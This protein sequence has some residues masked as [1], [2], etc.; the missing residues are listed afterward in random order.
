[1][2]WAVRHLPLRPIGLVGRIVFRKR[3]E[4]APRPTMTVA[5]AGSVGGVVL[6]VVA[7][8]LERQRAA[9]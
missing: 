6:L 7:A 4:R 2:L 1:M 9:R 3:I 8:E 5:G